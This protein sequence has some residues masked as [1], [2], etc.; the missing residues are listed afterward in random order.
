MKLTAKFSCRIEFHVSSSLPA[1]GSIC[2]YSFIFLVCL[3]TLKIYTIFYSNCIR[4][5]D[6]TLY[7]LYLFAWYYRLRFFFLE[8][9]TCTRNINFVVFL[10]IMSKFF[11]SNRTYRPSIL[12]SVYCSFYLQLCWKNFLSKPTL[13]SVLKSKRKT[14]VLGG[15]STVIKPPGQIRTLLDEGVR[16]NQEDLFYTQFIQKMKR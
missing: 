8:I 14:S 5:Y 15:G 9:F 6:E 7:I 3:L 4:R 2:L 1:C 16:R 12:G 13:T 11:S 10:T